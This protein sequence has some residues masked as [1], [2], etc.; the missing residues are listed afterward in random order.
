MY[1]DTIHQVFWTMVAVGVMVSLD[2]VFQL[3]WKHFAAFDVSVT[4]P[5]ISSLIA[6]G[7]Q[8]K[9]LESTNM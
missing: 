5:L 4:S 3:E 6:E 1:N 8:E 7:N 2:Y 9:K